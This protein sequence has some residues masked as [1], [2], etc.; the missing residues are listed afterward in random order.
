MCSNGSAE[1]ALQQQQWGLARLG[2]ARL[3]SALLGSAL[4]GSAWQPLLLLGSLCG[5]TAAAVAV[6][7]G[8]AATRG[9]HQAA[10]V[11][12]V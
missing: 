11:L 4:L 1:M 5:V 6:A 12:P 2:S 10:F 3:G 9:R 8:P 7:A